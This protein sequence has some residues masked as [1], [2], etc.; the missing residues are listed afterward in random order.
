M[1]TYVYKC[2]PC[3]HDFQKILRISQ[4]EAVQDCPE[5]GSGETEKQIQPVGFVLQGDGFPGKNLRIKEQMRTKNKRLTAK[6]RERR[7]DAP[8]LRLAP[9][10]GGERVDSWDEAKK[11]AASQGKD[12]QSY[13][14]K[15]REEKT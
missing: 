4:S 1:P 11:L 5:C 12:V 2:Q 7:H 9:N 8:G 3:G 10:V 6:S 15:A 13:E 14:P